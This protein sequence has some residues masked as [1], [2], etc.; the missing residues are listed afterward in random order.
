VPDFLFTD[1]SGP[2]HWRPHLESGLL[3]V[4]VDGATPVAFLAARATE[5]DLHIDEVDVLRDRQGAGLG[6]RLIGEAVAAARSRGCQAVTLTTFGDVPWN[7]PF[8]ARLG[9]AIWDDPPEAVVAI[10]RSEEARGLK[11]RVAMRLAL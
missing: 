6:R 5:D 7:A 8:Y 11:N 3:W 4:A 2:E 1:V 9:F 10:V